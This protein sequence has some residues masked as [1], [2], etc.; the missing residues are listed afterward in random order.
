MKNDKYRLKHDLYNRRIEIYEATHKLL[1]SLASHEKLNEDV[2]QK[3]LAI[4]DEAHFVF[5]KKVS[6]R[7]D[8]YYILSFEH[9]YFYGYGNTNFKIDISKDV[10]KI[11]SIENER[12]IDNNIHLN[13]LISTY[14]IKEFW[15]LKELFEKDISLL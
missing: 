7:I 2:F 4:K 13:G 3:F 12:V 9:R 10:R 14:A 8:E 5:S 1:N 11:L 15:S 6:K